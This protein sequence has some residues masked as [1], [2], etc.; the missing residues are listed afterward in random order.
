MKHLKEI[1]KKQLLSAD[2]DNQDWRS[3]ITA[4]SESLPDEINTLRRLEKRL[5]TL[6]AGKGPVGIIDAVSWAGGMDLVSQ[7][8]G[9]LEVNQWFH[10]AVKHIVSAYA[11]TALAHGKISGRFYKVVIA[12]QLATALDYLY[13]ATEHPHQYASLHAV[14][15]NSISLDI[16]DDYTLEN[17]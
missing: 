5:S 2:P 16:P 7:V 11:V 3:V 14:L 15:L 4:F 12:E 13:K 9:S 10:G 17:D 6:L 8:T 1:I